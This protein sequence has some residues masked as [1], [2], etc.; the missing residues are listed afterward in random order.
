MSNGKAGLLWA[1]VIFTIVQHFNNSFN[2]KPEPS[3]DRKGI[4]HNH[5]VLNKLFGITS[6]ARSSSKG[7]TNF[8]TSNVR[9]EN[10]I[11][12]LCLLLSGDVQTHPGPIVSTESDGN[13]QPDFC[14]KCDNIVEDDQY[15]VSCDVCLQWLHIECDN[16]T[17]QKYKKLQKLKQFNHICGQ[18]LI[19]AQ[20]F[21]T[22]NVLAEDEP[23]QQGNNNI[24]TS[25]NFGDNLQKAKGKGLTFLG[26]NARSLLPKI[27][28]LRYIVKEI[29][30]A[31]VGITE[32]WLDSSVWDSELRVDGYEIAR[33][34][35]NRDGGGVCMYV[36]NDI[37]FNHRK[38]INH[39]KIESVFVELNLPKCKPILVSTLYRPP[40][41][42]TFYS[43]LEECFQLCNF[44]IT[45][46]ESI[47]LGDYNTNVLVKAK[48]ALK[49]AMLKFAK[50][51]GLDQL[52]QEPTRITDSTK[53]LIDLIFVSESDKISQSG[54][55]PV[56]FSDHLITFCTRKVNRGTFEGNKTAKLRSFKN[57]TQELFIEKL[58]NVNW[59]PVIECENVN[60]AWKL[61]NDLFYQVIDKVAPEKDVRVKQRTE[62]WFTGEILENIKRRDQ[63]FHIFK[64]TNNK[65]HY[66]E[67]C[68]IR[69]A[70]SKLVKSTKENYY[71]DKIWENKNKPKKLWET[72]KDLGHTIKQN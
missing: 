13:Q 71:K 56:N 70:T 50:S 11:S 15:S 55:L 43:D 52:I 18:C 42:H 33:N 5:D 40:K 24:N 23:A 28:E 2:F 16:I 38:D 72:I 65:N 29:R 54:V 17:V 7:K 51:N 8:I 34:D 26:I 30:P 44:D 6:H 49:D 27:G 61:F 47:W 45:K 69:N 60:D 14:R 53:T 10:Y 67:Y 4:P 36:R 9:S 39:K 19:P 12:T 1:F 46:Y 25:F 57:Y 48:Y 63:A 66:K 3:C 58:Q 68:K 62:P 21:S 37:A 64:L 35:R 22:A 59:L 32:T 20:P 41:H 31:A